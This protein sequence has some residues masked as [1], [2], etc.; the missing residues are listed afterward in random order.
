PGHRRYALMGV[1]A[2]GK[3]RGVEA[4]LVDHMLSQLRYIHAIARLETGQDRPPLVWRRR[5][6]LATFQMC[7]DDNGLPLMETADITKLT[8][9][10]DVPS[11]FANTLAHMGVLEG[12][13]LPDITNELRLSA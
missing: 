9:R 4:G 3:G 6:E 2:Y 5:P 12:R 13:L 8:M 11:V 10:F 1:R 7:V